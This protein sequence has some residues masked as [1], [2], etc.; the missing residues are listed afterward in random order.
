MFHISQAKAFCNGRFTLWDPMITTPPGLYLLSAFFS[1]FAEKLFSFQLSSIAALRA[2][3]SVLGLGVLLISFAVAKELKTSHPFERSLI[4]ALLPTLYIFNFLY[5]TD[6]GSVFFTLLS[7]HG[8]LK[9]NWILYLLAGLV[10]LTFRQTNIIWV[11]GFFVGDIVHRRAGKLSLS[12]RKESL[13]LIYSA[14]LNR[15][16]LIF[17]A[18]LLLGCFCSFVYWNNG[19]IVLGDKQSHQVSAHWA[20]MLYFFSF[21]S[22]FFAPVTVPRLLS[23]NNTTLVFITS[24]GASVATLFGTIQHPYLLADNRH[25]TNVI[26]RH[27]LNRRICSNVRGR[28]ILAPAYGLIFSALN[29]CLIPDLIWRTCFILASALQLIP[30]PLFE[31]RYYL[32]PTIIFIFN[33]K[34]SKRKARMTLLWLCLINSVVIGLFLYRPFTLPTKPSE[35]QRYIW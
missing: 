33:M 35:L 23:S 24:L 20:Q 31:P 14:L 30:S 28:H 16:Q 4:M 32:I 22:V 15:K 7:Y 2:I 21:T 10:S 19:S 18:I 5:Y 11:A 13:R 25:L 29:D 12:K 34:I 1:Q 8:A 27:F 17:F 6:V 3:N 26:W 9:K